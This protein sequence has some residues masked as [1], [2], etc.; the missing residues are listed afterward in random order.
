MLPVRK[1]SQK[2]VK[3]QKSTDNHSSFDGMIQE[4]I[5]LF[6]ILL[7]CNGIPSTFLFSWFSCWNWN[8][9]AAAAAA[10]AAAVAAAAAAVRDI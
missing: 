1:N 5:D 6:D 10:A 7:S 8:Q 3:I 4:N 9:A 2:Q